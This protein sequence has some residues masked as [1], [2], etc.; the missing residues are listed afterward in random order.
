ME[1][2]S[3]ARTLGDDT[4]PGIASRAGLGG[5]PTGSGGRG[6]RIIGGPHDHRLVDRHLAAEC[7][8]A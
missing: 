5:G 7:D 8:L 2:A 1:A 4:E 3:R 6:T